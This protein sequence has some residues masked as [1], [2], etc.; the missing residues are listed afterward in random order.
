M[1]NKPVMHNPVLRETPQLK[2]IYFSL[3]RLEFSAMGEM[4]AHL[5]DVYRTL[6]LK[7]LAFAKMW[8]L[9]R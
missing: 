4:C 3:Q 1:H 6:N 5:K 7:V 9:Y 2:G 8:G